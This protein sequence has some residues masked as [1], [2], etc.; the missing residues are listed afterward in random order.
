MHSLVMS[1]IAEM[2]LLH[3]VRFPRS[4]QEQRMPR[5]G[6]RDRGNNGE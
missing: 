6:G 2:D 5:P 1:N 4:D 3:S